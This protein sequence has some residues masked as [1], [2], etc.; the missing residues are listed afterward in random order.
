M[1]QDKIKL[2]PLQRDILWTL[3]E[4]GSLELCSLICTVCERRKLGPFAVALADL[5]REGFLY[6]E[7]LDAPP[8]DVRQWNEP[9]GE[10]WLGD[11]IIKHNDGAME[12]RDGSIEIVISLAGSRVIWGERDQ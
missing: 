7:G 3:E 6:A 2:T 11:R 8:E 12:T 5:W 4:P 1:S 10:Q 9:A